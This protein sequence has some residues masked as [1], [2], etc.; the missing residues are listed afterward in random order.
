MWSAF[1]DEVEK[2]GAFMPPGGLR[3][4][5]NNTKDSFKRG[6]SGLASGT[7]SLLNKGLS[8]AR[9][10]VPTQMPGHGVAATPVNPI[11]G[12][13]VPSTVSAKPGM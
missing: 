1:L 2:T 6:L 3:T 4:L 8:S 13:T 10:A 5:A 11:P 9:G 12:A 7:K